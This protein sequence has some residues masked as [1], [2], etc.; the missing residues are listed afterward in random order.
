MLKPSDIKGVFGSNFFPQKFEKM[1]KLFRILQRFLK[2]LS[3]E[4]AFQIIQEEE[5]L[6]AIDLDISISF[7]WISEISK[8]MRI[9]DLASFVSLQQNGHRFSKYQN[10]TRSEKTDSLLSVLSPTHIPL[11]I[12][13]PT[14]SDQTETVEVEM[15]AAQTVASLLY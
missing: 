11:K 14:N 9:Y 8:T 5:Y 2:L 6:E 10:Y 1:Q 12:F 13:S 15:P 7:L 4:R 3:F